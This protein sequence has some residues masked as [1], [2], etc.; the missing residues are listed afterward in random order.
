MVPRLGYRSVV[1]PK[2]VCRRVH[3][4]LHGDL[5]LEFSETKAAFQEVLAQASWILWIS[6]FPEC[7]EAKWDVGQ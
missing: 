2:E 6:L 7:L 4:Q 1:L 3:P 5:A